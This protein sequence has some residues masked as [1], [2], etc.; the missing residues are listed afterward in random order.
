MGIGAKTRLRGV[1]VPSGGVVTRGKIL[2]FCQV[3]MRVLLDPRRVGEIVDRDQS[4]R[5]F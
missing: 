2:L 3:E 4:V 5:G 1:R